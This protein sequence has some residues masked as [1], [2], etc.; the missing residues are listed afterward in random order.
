MPIKLT[1]LKK[2][3]NNEIVL[4]DS[5]R[6]KEKKTL[7]DGETVLEGIR[8][9][10]DLGYDELYA[11]LDPS[12]RERKKIYDEMLN[13]TADLTV[14]LVD[15]NRQLSKRQEEV[16]RYIRTNHVSEYKSLTR[17]IS[18]DRLNAVTPLGG[19]PEDREYALSR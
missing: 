13:N 19:A 15:R 14:Y 7:T 8:L 11:N 6:E 16:E 10:D 1:R 18:F 12:V 2:V 3:K 17:R 9:A 5:N 4:A